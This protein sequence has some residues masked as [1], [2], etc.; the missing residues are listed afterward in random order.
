MYIIRH[1]ITKEQLGKHYST[2]A[3]AKGAF[4]TAYM[5]YDKSK[6]KYLKFSEQDIYEVVKEE[7]P[8]MVALEEAVRL[9]RIASTSLGNLGDFATE[10]EIDR[11]LEGL[12]E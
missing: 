4:K 6:G 5:M 10:G 12:Y 7:T 8:E 1:K 3:T 11:F 2:A 9:L